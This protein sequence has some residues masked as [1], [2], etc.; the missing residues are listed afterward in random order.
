MHEG[1]YRVVLDSSGTHW[2]RPDGTPLDP[3]AHP[4]VLEGPG[5]VE[6]NEQL[7]L[8]ITPDTPVARWDGSGV[9]V[10]WCVESL[11]AADA[12]PQQAPTRGPEPPQPGQSGN[13][14]T[15]K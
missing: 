6:Q 4:P 10:S 13:R 2:T 11:L 1:G 3:S 7:G 12:Q 9:D 5:V 15:W 14:C 8:G